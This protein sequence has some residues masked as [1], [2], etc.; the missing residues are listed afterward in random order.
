MKRHARLPWLP[1]EDRIVDRYARDLAAGRQPNLARAAGPC[2]RDISRLYASLRKSGRAHLV[3][4][5]PRTFI[6]IRRRLRLRL[7]VLGLAWTCRNVSS[8]EKHVIER[9]AAALARGKYRNAQE[10]AV[11]CKSAIERLPKGST[12]PQGRSLRA[13]QSQIYS[14]ALRSGRAWAHQKWLHADDA[15]VR[16]YA[17]AVISGKYPSAAS[18]LPACCRELAA[19]PRPGRQQSSVHKRLLETMRKLGLSRHPRWRDDE[20]RI[21]RR[22]L[23]LL[24][25]G[26][27]KYLRGRCLRGQPPAARRLEPL[28]ADRLLAHGSLGERAQPAQVQ[29]RAHARGT[30]AV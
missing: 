11:A 15:I 13:I 17:L 1:E 28:C 26:R 21:F 25:A 7:G 16:R 5:H 9:H 22:H 14:R 19:G 8:A 10:A 12:P 24:F 6:S 4:A 30:P 29:V 27:Y 20:E 23:R 3:A 18:A 2:Q